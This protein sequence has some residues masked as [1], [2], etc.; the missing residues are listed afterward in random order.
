MWQNLFIVAERADVYQVATF[1]NA[2]GV[3]GLNIFN[4]MTFD[5]TKGESNNNLECIIKKFD[6]YIIGSVNE[7]Y[8]RFRFNS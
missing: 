4:G 1:K 8:E 5:A 3:Q 6:D 2:I 7:T